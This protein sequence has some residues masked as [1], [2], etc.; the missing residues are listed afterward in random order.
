MDLVNIEEA[1][2]RRGRKVELILILE[3]V[4]CFYQT[5]NNNSVL[6][7]EPR[8]LCSRARGPGIIYS[9]ALYVMANDEVSWTRE[10]PTL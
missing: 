1:R 5:P 9:G 4:V 7:C 3:L 2:R 8:R 10:N 6:L